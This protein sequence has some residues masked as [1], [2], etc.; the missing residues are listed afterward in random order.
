MKI[1]EKIIFG[2]QVNFICIIFNLK[3]QVLFP[4]MVAEIILE[5]N[6]N[7]DYQK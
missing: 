4:H 3:C 1:Y 6:S 7:K 2:A 5:H